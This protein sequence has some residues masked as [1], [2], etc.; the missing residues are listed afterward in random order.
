MV[1]DGQG[2]SGLT[3][4]PKPLPEGIPSESQYIAWYCE[5]LRCPPPDPATWRFYMALSLFRGAAILAGVGARAA[6]GN[7]SSRSA[8]TVGSLQVPLAETESTCAPCS[9]IWHFA[10]TYRPFYFKVSSLGHGSAL[11]ELICDALVLQ[12][13]SSIAK[14]ALSIALD[15]EPSNNPTP[16]LTPQPQTAGLEPSPRAQELLVRLRAFMS[17]H[18]YPAEAALTQLA[19]SD[20]RW[21]IHPL[22]EELKLK[23]GDPIAST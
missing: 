5:A 3:G 4:L 20:R 13:V 12:V 19:T 17:D 11:H 23:Y 2:E 1:C 18:V 22:H 21:T 9:V 7:A 8:T 10:R 16:T 6:L 15:Q 14:M